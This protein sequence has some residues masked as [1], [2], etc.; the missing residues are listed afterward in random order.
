M[1]RPQDLGVQLY[2]VRDALAAD[3]PVTI[4][5]LAAIGFGYVEPFGLLA[6][7]AGLDAALRANGLRAITAHA[8]V[9]GPDAF[10]LCE[11][12]TA[13]G[14]ATLI[15]PWLDP[16]RFASRD[17]VRGVAD[18]LNRTAAAVAGHGIQVGYHNHWFELEAVFEGRTALEWL[19]DDLD[20]GIVLEVDTYWAA[21]GGQDVPALL[22]R[23]GDRVRFLHL[24]DGPLEPREPQVALG[25]GVLPIGAILAAAPQIELAIVELDSFDGDMFD[26]LADSVAFLTELP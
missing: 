13:L 19:A 3:M 2:A 18:E 5:R 8:P 17:A 11:A 16:E 10:A 23:L 12:A 15:V 24:K 22:G 14:I 21:V 20:D 7:P 26:A 25:R 1:T 9:N 6:D 4:E